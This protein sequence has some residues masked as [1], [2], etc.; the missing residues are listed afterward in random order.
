MIQSM[1]TRQGGEPSFPTLYSW[2]TPASPRWGGGFQ[3]TRMAV[4]LVSLFVTVTPCGARLGAKRMKYTVYHADINAIS[5]D[6][7]SFL[8]MVCISNSFAHYKKWYLAF[9]SS[10]KYTTIEKKM[11]ELQQCYSIHVSYCRTKVFIHLLPMSWPP[12]PH[13]Q[14]PGTHQRRDA[15]WTRR[16]ILSSADR[17]P[18]RLPAGRLPPWCS[19]APPAGRVQ[20]MACKTPCNPGC[21]G[22]AARPSWDVEIQ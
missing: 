13:C 14:P 19:T 2:M 8:G 3:A 21:T 18:P 4:P 17:S 6:A 10:S 16:W 9:V 11:K 5:S 20:R 7:V 1:S 15:L 12:S 22:T